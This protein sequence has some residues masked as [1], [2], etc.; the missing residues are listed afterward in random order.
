MVVVQSGKQDYKRKVESKITK[1]IKARLA[2]GKQDYKS[3]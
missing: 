1:A 3:N 2:S